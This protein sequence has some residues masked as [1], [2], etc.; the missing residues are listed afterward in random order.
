M[1][2]LYPILLILYL[3]GLLFIFIMSDRIVDSIENIQ[4]N[5]KT[6][7]QM[8]FIYNALENGW[9]IS[10]KN[11][12]YIFSKKHCN[13]REVFKNTYLAKFIEENSNIKNII[14]KLCSP[15]IN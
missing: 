3:S 7:K 6:L 5:Q 10:K 14:S 4:Y 11:D 9:K 13:K 15:S 12:S 1:N 2:L 8:I